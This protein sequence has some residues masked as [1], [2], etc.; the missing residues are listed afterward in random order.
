ERICVAAAEPGSGLL[1]TVPVGAVLP[2]QLGSAGKVL[3]AYDPDYRGRRP[4]RAELSA[5]RHAGWAASS[6]ERETGVASVSVP[7]LDGDRILGA[8]SISGPAQRFDQV[9]TRRFVPELLEAARR[10]AEDALGQPL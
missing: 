4:A 3:L 9:A 7:V 8:L 5:I 2:L 1:D 10:L 6:E